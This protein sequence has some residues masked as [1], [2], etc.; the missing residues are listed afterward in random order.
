MNEQFVLAFILQ[1]MQQ[2]NVCR[3]HFEPLLLYVDADM[4][5][6]LDNEWWYLLDVPEGIEIG[7]DS[8]YYNG[9]TTSLNQSNVAEFTGRVVIH[10]TGEKSSVQLRFIRLIIQNA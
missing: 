3:F 2:M 10:V 1:R 9:N 6:R 5:F 4:Q 8:A 7:S